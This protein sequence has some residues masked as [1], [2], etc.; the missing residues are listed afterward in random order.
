MV[1]GD[2]KRSMISQQASTY[3]AA[4]VSTESA[5]GLPSKEK[6]VNGT[7][8]E[9]TRMKLNS[10]HDNGSTTTTTTTKNSIQQITTV[11]NTSA[12]VGTSNNNKTAKRI[13]SP[14]RIKT[15]C[16]V[17]CRMNPNLFS[18]DVKLVITTSHS[19]SESSA[20][21]IDA[22]MVHQPKTGYGSYSEKLILSTQTNGCCN[23]LTAGTTL[24]DDTSNITTTIS[25]SRDSYHMVW[26]DPI[27]H[28][29][30][31][32][33]LIGKRIR[34]SIKQHE[35]HTG[36]GKTTFDGEV[37]RIRNH[38]ANETSDIELLIDAN[39]LQVFPVLQ[40]LE[41]NTSPDQIRLLSKKEKRLLELEQRVARGTC[42]GDTVHEKRQLVTVGITLLHPSIKHTNEA[43]N[44]NKHNGPNDKNDASIN[45]CLV[46]HKW[47]VQKCIPIDFAKKNRKRK[48][49]HDANRQTSTN[50]GTIING[51]YEKKGDDTT[52]INSHDGFK[53]D[54]TSE[55]IEV[56]D[57][58]IHLNGN[59]SH[60]SQ[61][62]ASTGLLGKD[63][64]QSI[65]NN[66]SKFITSQKLRHTLGN[67]DVI[68]KRNGDT[69]KT[70][71]KSATSSKTVTSNGNS[72]HKAISR[73]I[74]DGNDTPDQQINNWRFF[75]C[76]Y[77]DA[78]FQCRK[79]DSAEGCQRIGTQLLQPEMLSCGFIGKVVRVDPSA[80]PTK[81]LAMVTICRM[82]LP[83][84]TVS[85]RKDTHGW[86]DVYFDYD[87]AFNELRTDTV[88]TLPIEQLI[89]VSRNAGDLSD[90]QKRSDDSI[91]DGAVSHQYYSWNSD[92]Y[93]PRPFH[94]SKNNQVSTAAF[95]DLRNVLYCH[96]CRQSNVE[97]S[98]MTICDSVTCR[99]KENFRLT[100]GSAVPVVA[101]CHRCI[102][103]MD[104]V[105][106]NS[107][108][109]NSGNAGK[110][111]PCCDARC[112]CFTCGKCHASA[113]PKKIFSQVAMVAKDTKSGTHTVDRR[114]AKGDILSSSA[115][116]LQTF[117]WAYDFSLPDSFMDYSNLPMP[118]SKP[119][120]RI[121]QRSVRTVKRFTKQVVV[122][123][124]S[125]TKQGQ[126]SKT[127]DKARLQNGRKVRTRTTE[128]GV[129][130][131][132][133]PS[134]PLLLKRN[135]CAREIVYEASKKYSFKSWM[136][137]VRSSSIMALEQP[138]SLRA[139]QEPSAR[140][141]TA[142][143]N[144]ET[145]KA[146]SSRAA[147]ASQRRLL[148][149]VASFGMTA[150]L[151][152]TLANREPQLRFDRSKIHAW[153]VFADT[154]ITMGAMIVEYRGE[155][156]GNAV[157][158]LREKEYEAAKIGSD[159]MF[160]IDSLTVCDATKQGNVA[161]FINAS[162]D[163]NCYTKIIS[164]D[165]SK[166]I[167]IYAKKDIQAGDELCY[168]YKFPIE[169]DETKRI[170]CHCAARECRGYM[171]WV[172]K[173][174]ELL[175]YDYTFHSHLFTL[176]T[177]HQD[178]KY[179]TKPTGDTVQSQTTSQDH[180]SLKCASEEP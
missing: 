113:A 171:N 93:V 128:S 8:H 90:I 107:S 123:R 37:I 13:I 85:G 49:T 21:M 135:H 79:A 20:H 56:N 119:M 139:L 81:T 176:R 154:A 4:I 86:N 112:D 31:Y 138:R 25:Y 150:G 169:Y 149:D 166:R 105:G 179:V 34:C 127:G 95:M 158:E 92:I 102:R 96:R 159:Y 170:R 134:K 115:S 7:H 165:G 59:P 136:T 99:Y 157:A 137:E 174:W 2:R 17:A 10:V 40:P 48:L 72:K 161:R 163:P 26:T 91:L 62:N 141:I 156:I 30:L 44:D 168:D 121:I 129:V 110:L 145:V 126:Q 11:A 66:N 57:G 38:H 111:L 29:D 97:I 19:K 9:G 77:H 33:S 22:P 51:S 45:R 89:V 88:I 147:R 172:S 180:K 39:L 122:P 41:G 43:T 146:S 71:K 12:A 3:Q 143:Q 132:V 73:Y 142:A 28:R 67:D 83:E 133:M 15:G 14:F 101:W 36:N 100:I 50:N 27:P 42:H 117:E 70:E 108:V 69:I 52:T 148:K 78:Q 116:L 58:P 65:I 68:A 47:V 5:Q 177:F 153:G 23:S 106:E 74:G 178:K 118:Q 16:I 109:L 104:S 46:V 144:D 167:V 35:Q 55:G 160:R 152:D 75:A 125:G 155:L 76:R 6:H 54:N 60:Q 120:T 114:F 103:A 80:A 64:P 124:N 151:V 162:C 18:E 61:P 32:W 1:M 87:N 53:R 94:E 63:N 98:K 164:F 24:N 130:S 82:F 140:L 173:E 84:H 131:M 175:L